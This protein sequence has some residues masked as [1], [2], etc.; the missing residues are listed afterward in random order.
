VLPPTVQVNDVAKTGGAPA[1]PVNGGGGAP[2]VLSVEVLGPDRSL[3]GQPLAYEIV[4]RNVGRQ[5]IAELHVEEPVPTDARIQKA[6]PPAVR[7]GD[8][9]IWDLPYLEVGGERRLKVELELSRAGELH[10]RP[11]VSCPMGNAFRTQVLR[12]PFSIAI[13]ADRTRVTRGEPVRF[14]IQ[15]A[16]NGDVPVR[17]IKIYDTLPSGLHHPRGPKIGVEH[18]GD[19]LPGQ[20][21]SLPLE[22]IAVES[23]T[24]HH[25]VLAQ[26]DRGVEAKAAVDLVITEPNLS[27]RMD[28]PD[29]TA[30][31]REVDFHLEVANPAA[32]TAKEVRLVQALPPT[33]EVVSA[34]TGA[35]FDSIHHTLV[36]SL[37]DLGAGQRHRVTFRLKAHE[38]GDW[39]MTAAVLTQNF[40]E[41]RVTHTLHAQATAIL[42]LEVH[43]REER[44]AVGDE[45]ICRIHVF[46]KGDAPCVGVQLS[47]V[48]PDAVLPFQAEGPSKGQIENQQV[49]FAPLAQLDA[50]GDVVYAIPMRGQ[51][52]GKGPIRVKLTAEKQVPVEK[53]ISIQVHATETVK[54]LSGEMLR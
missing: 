2:A 40:P 15:L 6:D 39:P 17:N 24:F 8:R 12:P 16:N 49:R 47:A 25:E 9:L 4:V 50:H 11:Y 42:Q 19:L 46:N 53:A 33:F 35:V 3:L 23:G 31:Q 21:R 41:A 30:T 22:T 27:L 7:Q 28:G 13:S 1:P 20:T 5:A 52:A 29:T 26:A 36:W 45:T 51:Q 37:T 48:L 44:L 18:F 38:G 10:L 43:A 54:S 32:L 34:S 14:R